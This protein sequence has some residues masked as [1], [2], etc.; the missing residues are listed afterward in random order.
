MWTKAM[1]DEE[2]G[3]DR[4]RDEPLM[5]DVQIAVA[6]VDPTELPMVAGRDRCDE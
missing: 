5:V 6:M 3:H 2:T 1:S 4:D